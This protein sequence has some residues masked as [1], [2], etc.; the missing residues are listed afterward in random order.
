MQIAQSVQAVQNSQALS[1]YFVIEATPRP[2]HTV[3][4][5][6]KVIDE[7]IARLQRE[8]PTDHEVQRALN[9][10]ES[11]FYSRMERVGGFGGKA[12]QLNG[13]FVSTGDPDWFNE[14][15]A[16]TGRS[17][18]PTSGPPPRRFSRRAGASS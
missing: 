11:S 16:A 14:D 6:Q 2:G 15:L 7:E 5:L 18:R 10:I 13:Y 3:E 17:L 8:P 12:D 4:E 1:S 9:Q